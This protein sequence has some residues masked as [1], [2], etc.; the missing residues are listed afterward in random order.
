MLLVTFSDG[1]RVSI[2]AL[3]RQRAEIVDLCAA[4]PQLPPSMLDFVALGTDALDTA[5]RVIATGQHRLAEDRVHLLAPIP[6]P[7]RNI[8]CLGKNYAAHAHEVRSIVSGGGQ[9][10]AVPKYPV[11]F[12]KAPSCVIGPGAPIPIKLDPTASVDYEGEFTV[13]IGS[14][15]RGITRA[16]A[17][18]H[19]FGYTIIN[20]VTSRKLQRQHLQWFLGK[21]LDGFCPMGPVIVTADEVADVR[22]LQLQTRVNQELRQDGRIGD[23]IFDVPT[24]IET[25]SRGMTLQPGDLIATGT[26]AGVGAGFDPPRF[27]QQGDIVEITI[28][29]IGTLTNRAG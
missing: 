10:N 20:D 4:A 5:R 21:S 3:D 7:A 27:L 2:G 26:P 23:L 16:D 29:P 19:V 12:T 22:E 15:G 6:R 18:A 17:M 11:V 13:V 14:G 1:K 8:F 24:L 28:E 9:E 25:L